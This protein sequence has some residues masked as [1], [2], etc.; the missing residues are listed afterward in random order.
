MANRVIKAWLRKSHLRGK[1]TGYF[2]TIESAGSV[3]LDEI[4]EELQKDGLE[5]N[6]ATVKDVATRLNQKCTDLLLQGLHVNNGLVHMHPSI[7]GIF[8]NRIWSSKNSVHISISQGKELR[9]AVAE[10]KVEIL[11]EHP[12]PTAIFTL[13]DL[14]TGMTDGTLTR[15]FNAEVKGTYIRIAGTDPDCGIYFRNDDWQIDYKLPNEYIVLNDPS[16]VLILI[17]EELEPN[18]Y[19]MRIVT[20]YSRAKQLLKNSRSVIYQLPVTIL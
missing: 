6:P 4:I 12:D 15:K 8:Q 10:T 11:G 5:L 3:G 16:R 19:E 14:S 7:K 18:T 17:P 1:S 20:Q 9:E 13:T 2:A